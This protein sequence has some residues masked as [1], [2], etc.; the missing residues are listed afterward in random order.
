M[1]GVECARGREFISVLKEVIRLHKPTVLA[2]VET[3]M[4]GEQVVRIATM[5]GYSGHT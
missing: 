4:G 5:L 1:Y 2:L 3:H